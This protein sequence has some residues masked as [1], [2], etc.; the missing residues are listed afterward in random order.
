MTYLLVI[1][2]IILVAIWRSIEKG[3]AIKTIHVELDRARHDAENEQRDLDRQHREYETY[4]LANGFPH[5]NDNIRVTAWATQ[6]R[7]NFQDAKQ[8][9]LDCEIDEFISKKSAPPFKPKA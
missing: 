2:A 3:N 7:M 6:H 4:Y 9:L 1:I 8:A 5:H